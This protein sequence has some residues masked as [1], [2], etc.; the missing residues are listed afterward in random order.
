M[1]DVINHIG[2]NIE[3]LK[4]KKHFNICFLE[5]HRLTNK[6]KIDYM[7]KGCPH[8]SF[9][10]VPLLFFLFYCAETSSIII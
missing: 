2:I 5:A 6:T 9:K 10:K 8:I 3:K 7:K 4:L 1:F